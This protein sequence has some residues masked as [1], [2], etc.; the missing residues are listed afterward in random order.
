MGE[1]FRIVTGVILPT[2]PQRMLVCQ[3]E[4]RKELFVL[5]FDEEDVQ[6]LPETEATGK[7]K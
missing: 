6:D 4:G 1:Q 7:N 3:V 5:S 2:W